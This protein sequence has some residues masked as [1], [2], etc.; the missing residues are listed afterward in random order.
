MRPSGEPG[1]G[2]PDAYDEL[3]SCSLPGQNVRPIR[4]LVPSSETGLVLRGA[5]SLVLGFSIFAAHRFY[6]HSSHRL[7][8]GC[9]F[10]N[11]PPI[12]ALGGKGAEVYDPPMRR[13]SSTCQTGTGKTDVLSLSD[14]W[15]LFRPSG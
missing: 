8:G 13:Q 5:D 15:I 11:G 6:A 4:A 2:P 9:D 1:M 10:A 14:S 3:P 12:F 7:S